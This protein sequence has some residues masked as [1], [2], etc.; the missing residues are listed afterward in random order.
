VFVE[1]GAGLGAART[2]DDFNNAG[3][4]VVNDRKLYLQTPM[5]SC[6]SAVLPTK[7]STQ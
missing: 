6:A 4:K 7:F 1:S 3:A 5:L 2:D